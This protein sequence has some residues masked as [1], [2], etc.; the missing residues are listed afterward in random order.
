MGNSTSQGFDPLMFSDDDYH[1]V[2]DGDDDNI[3]IDII[4]EKI[5]ERLDYTTTDDEVDIIC[6][7]R[8]SVVDVLYYTF[9]NRLKETK[10]GRFMIGG[11]IGKERQA[12]YKPF[13][14]KLIKKGFTSFFLNMAW[15]V[16]IDRGLN[17]LYALLKDIAPLIY[18]L[19]LI[20]NV[21][22]GNYITHT[23][24]FCA[25]G[26]LI[27]IIKNNNEAKNNKRLLMGYQ[28]MYHKYSF[29]P[30]E[31]FFIDKNIEVVS[32]VRKDDFVLFF[33]FDN[34]LYEINS[35]K[36]IKVDAVY[37][38]IRLNIKALFTSPTQVIMIYILTMEGNVYGIG[39]A[40]KVSNIVI[41]P[42]T[43]EPGLAK[44]PNIVFITSWCNGTSTYLYDDVGDLYVSIKNNIGR[45]KKVSPHLILNVDSEKK[46]RL[47]NVQYFQF[48]DPADKT[49]FFDKIPYLDKKWLT[50]IARKDLYNP[51]NIILAT[52]T[53]S[54]FKPRDFYGMYDLDVLLSNQKIYRFRVTIGKDFELDGVVLN[55]PVL[56]DSSSKKPNLWIFQC[57]HCDEFKGS[58]KV[59]CSIDRIFCNVEC[60]RAHYQYVEANLM[61][62]MKK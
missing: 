18:S 10:Y 52:Y 56:W 44:I 59:D 5:E 49:P 61:D 48:I 9:L 7:I 57:Q 50:S 30:L 45:F 29:T 46:K 41:R 11:T 51:E 4:K 22:L 58:L 27:Y 39:R 32:I 1:D 24:T 55:E 13:Y 42:I 34:N 43:F 31:A 23:N 37:N 14:K 60:Q 38:D 54:Y 15:N 47:L 16:R 6:E 3:D 26:S 28:L 8:Q 53:K 21:Y 19:Y 40:S 33:D 20:D 36:C 62:M 17:D 35:R 12:Y 25:S 2:D